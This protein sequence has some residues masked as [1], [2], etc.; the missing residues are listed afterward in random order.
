MCFIPIAISRVRSSINFHR[1]RSA[2]RHSFPWNDDWRISMGGLGD[3]LGRRGVLMVSM[4]VN[5][6]FGMLS[7]LAMSF[8]KC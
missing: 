6:I 3:S 4:T 2:L 5:A 1:Q 8:P 7:S